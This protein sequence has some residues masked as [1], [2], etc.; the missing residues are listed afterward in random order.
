MVNV[1]SFNRYPACKRT[2]QNDIPSRQTDIKICQPLNQPHQP[3][4]RISWNQAMAFC[5]WLSHQT[6][7][8]YSL[9]TEAQWEFTCRAGAPADHAGAGRVWGVDSMPASVAEW[10]RTTYRPYPYLLTDGRDDVSLRGRKVVRGAKALGPAANRRDTYRLSYHGWHG[11]WDVGFRVVCEDD[12]PAPKQE[13]PDSVA[14]A[15]IA[16]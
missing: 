2:G 1:A 15:Q 5:D 6:G 7:R 16:P 9:P 11:V 4:I 12:E 13:E 14:R 8:R 3:V 10:T